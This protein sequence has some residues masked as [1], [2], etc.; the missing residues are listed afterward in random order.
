[1]KAAPFFIMTA[2]PI[3]KYDKA[4]PYMVGY[5]YFP[6]LDKASEKAGKMAF[7]Y[8][9]DEFIYKVIAKAVNKNI[10]PVYDIVTL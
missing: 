10:Q 4:H 9:S 6:T 7:K 3:Y 2:D 1:V 8:D 5:Q